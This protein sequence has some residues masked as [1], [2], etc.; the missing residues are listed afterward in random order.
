MIVDGEQRQDRICEQKYDNRVE[1]SQFPLHVQRDE[2][3]V[4][5]FQRFAAFVK[6]VRST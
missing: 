2:D 3:P 4:D 1:T 6:G 5:H